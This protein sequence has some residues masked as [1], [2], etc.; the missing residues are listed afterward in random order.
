VTA[1]HAFIAA[2][3]HVAAPHP[4]WREAQVVT[5]IS[6]QLGARFAQ[7]QVTM[8]QASRG[9]PPDAGLERFIYLIEGRLTLQ[10][11][12]QQHTLDQ[13]SFAYLP[14]YLPHQLDCPQHAKLMVF[15]RRYVAL[16][17]TP[18]PQVVTGHHE[19]VTAEPFLG[20]PD[21]Q[22][23]RLLPD[24]APFDMAVNTMR[25]APGATLPFVETHIMEHGLLMLQGGGIYRLGDAWYPITQGDV[26]WMGPY[27][28][29]WFG[30]L[31]RTHASYLLYKEVNRD[32]FAFLRES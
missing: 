14:A 16:P 27:C 22:V 12:A 29:Q 10:L 11:E 13:G 6:P 26:L 30:A 20:D 8:T 31:G 4:S 25:F 19:D 5:L 3:G 2:D 9:T 17:D 28:P 18:T 32:A 24:A 7:Y 21:V 1:S 15:E 23:R